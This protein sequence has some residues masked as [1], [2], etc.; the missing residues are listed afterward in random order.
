[1]IPSFCPQGLLDLVNPAYFCFMLTL[2]SLQ[3]GLLLVLPPF[4]QGLAASLTWF[5]KWYQALGHR[6]ISFP[7][8]QGI[9][10]Y[11]EVREALLSNL[12]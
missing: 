1:M 8:A 6:F 11:S 4:L 9:S 12:L 3:E 5:F 2:G 7:H 10:F